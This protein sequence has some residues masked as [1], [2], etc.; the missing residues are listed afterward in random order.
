MHYLSHPSRIL[1]VMT[2]E[3]GAAATPKQARSPGEDEERAQL[4]AE[5][6]QLTLPLMWNM[7]QD[8]MH[9]FE[10]LGMKP[11]QALIMGIIGE[12]TCTPSELAHLMETTAPMMS[13][14]LA[15]L[16]R[17]DLVERHPD[18]NDRRRTRVELTKQ[19]ERM[20]KK[21]DQAWQ[22]ASLSRTERLSTD[23]LRE[24]VRLYT[25][26]TDEEAPE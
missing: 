10:P 23:D 13:T 7:R 17:H 11:I 25:L 12:R 5:L 1:P 26:L 18:P 9:A 6:S 22:E 24:L 20:N 21:F 15:D 14:M 4:N 8:A 2:S 16:E 3:R 19:G